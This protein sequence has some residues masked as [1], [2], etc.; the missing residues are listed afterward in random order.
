MMNFSVKAL[1]VAVV[2]LIFLNSN[3]SFAQITG[4]SFQSAKSSGTANLKYV[5]TGVKGF[6]NQ[7]G[8]EV[9]GLLID[10]MREFEIFVQ[11]KH[12]ITVKANFVQVANSDFQQF[13]DDVK[14]GSGGVFGL[15]TTTIK[16][17][18]KN[19]LKFSPAYLNNISV[20]VSHKNI[21]TLSSIDNI[22][23]EFRSLT[24]ITAPGTTYEK[25][26]QE[27]KSA[28]FPG[29]RIKEVAGEYDIVDG[30]IAD[31][32]SF[33]F[34]DISYYL[35]YLKDGKPIK[36][37]PAGDKGGEQYGIIMPMNSDWQP[38]ITEFLNSGFLSSP[39]Y[40]QIVI[41]QLGKG[42]LRMLK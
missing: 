22:G 8:N 13:L 17:E 30:V 25:R 4:D 15:N 41:N 28:Q 18:R 38:V 14:N 9:K 31:P 32:N 40:R 42:A 16:E 1:R 33:G 6:A 27:V 39:K 2:A 7:E 23:S 21:A 11:D 29:L 10:L 5:Y 24:A 19:F 35:E 12:G 36:R 26:I 20:L 3:V 34:V 37:H